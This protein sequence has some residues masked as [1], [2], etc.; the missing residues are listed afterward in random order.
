MR[1]ALENEVNGG[2]STEGRLLLAINKKRC[3]DLHQKVPRMSEIRVV[4]NAPPEELH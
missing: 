1:H 3:P 4:F 2:S